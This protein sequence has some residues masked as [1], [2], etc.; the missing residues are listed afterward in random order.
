[1]T[2]PKLDPITRELLRNSLVNIVGNMENAMLR[3]AFSLV[4]R[5]F[6]DVACGLHAGPDHALDL[7]AVAAG[8]PIL[9]VVTHFGLKENVAE[10]GVDEL[11]PG[12]ELSFND[13]FRGGNHAPDVTI[14]RPIFEGDELIAFAT[15][16]S[17]WVDV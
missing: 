5:D 15:S 16:R 4:A 14:A 9:S 12:D 13:P 1:M 7:V 10:F 8:V 3:T 11:R 17:H 6:R 2:D